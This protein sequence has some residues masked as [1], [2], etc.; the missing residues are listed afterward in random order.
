[1]GN[2]DWHGVTDLQKGRENVMKNLLF[3]IAAALR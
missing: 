3:F 1:M 2:N